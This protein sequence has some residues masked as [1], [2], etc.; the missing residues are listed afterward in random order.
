MFHYNSVTWQTQYAKTEQSTIVCTTTLC[1]TQYLIVNCKLYTK[2]KELVTNVKPSICTSN[3]I[4]SV[5]VTIEHFL[6]G[7]KP[8]CNTSQQSIYEDLKLTI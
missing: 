8:T 2:Y 5:T 7:D 3:L 1:T 6:Q 4:N